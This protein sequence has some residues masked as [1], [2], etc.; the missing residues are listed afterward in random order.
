MG[1]NERRARHRRAIR[2]RYQAAGKKSKAIILDE[3]CQVCRYNHPPRR[4]SDQ[5]KIPTI[6]TPTHP[7][8]AD[9]LKPQQLLA[10]IK[11][12]PQGH[13][14]HLLGL[15]RLAERDPQP[16]Q[17]H[18]MVLVAKLSTMKLLHPSIKL[19]DDI[20]HR[21]GTDLGSKQTLT[22]PTHLPGCVT[23]QKRL[24]QHPINPP[25]AD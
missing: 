25:S 17:V 20:R 21:L 7:P 12:D 11:A 2:E 6:T 22:Q 10:P 19:S 24:Q 9:Y 5:I 3:F 15:H 13:Q 16:I 14:Q 8:K 23:Q 18:K 1:N 4:A